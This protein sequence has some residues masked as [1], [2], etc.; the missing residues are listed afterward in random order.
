[1]GNKH[2]EAEKN[3]LILRNDA[4]DYVIIPAKYRVEVQDMIKNRCWG[5]VDNLVDTLPVME[6]YAE[7]G[8]LIPD[9]PPK[10]EQ[11]VWFPKQPVVP[12]ANATGVSEQPVLEQ[13]Q[14][15]ADITFKNIVEKQQYWDALPG[16]YGSMVKGRENYLDNWNK[17]IPVKALET[18]YDIDYVT[19]ELPKGLQSLKSEYDIAESNLAKLESDLE[20]ASPEQMEI[21]QDDI[22]EAKRKIKDIRRKWVGHYE[23]KEYEKVPD[24]TWAELIT[25]NKMVSDPA[26]L[27]ASLMDEGADKFAEKDYFQGK[28]S[29]YTLFG[30]DTFGDRVDEF[31]NKGYVDPSIKDRI[32]TREKSNEL[33]MTVSAPLFTNLDDVIAA[34]NAFILSG[35]DV[36]DEKAKELGVNLSNKAR[37]YFTVVTF[38]RG[39]QG[40]KD[41]MEYYDEQGWLE[42]EEFLTNE[43]LP[44]KNPQKHYNALRRIQA[45]DMLRGE[46]VITENK[47]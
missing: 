9:W 17:S 16:K 29:G 26:L 13:Q 34:K 15:Y 35:R 27:Y 12:M 19:N 3:E 24:R 47:E 39:E 6:D 22:Y 25:G 4:G 10:G 20:K 40:A 42:T 38:N 44:L 46:G 11:P 36:I 41:L 18:K 43:K 21:I 32:K 5:C 33:G 37:D 45:I 7:D 8:T 23:N 30:L 28:L 1:M 31:I 2:I 14:R